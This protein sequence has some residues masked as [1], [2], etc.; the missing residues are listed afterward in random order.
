MW[1]EI[2]QN[3]GDIQGDINFMWN[4]NPL[5]GAQEN[6]NNNNINNNNNNN[7]NNRVNNNP[8]ISSFHIAQANMR[9]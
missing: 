9:N 4:E 8:Y 1:N 6:N 2:H 7:R 5:F 3:N